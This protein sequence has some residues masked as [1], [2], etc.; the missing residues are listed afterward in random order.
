MKVIAFLL[1]LKTLKVFVQARDGKLAIKG[2]KAALTPDIKKQLGAAKQAIIDLYSEHGL[3]SNVQLAPVTQGQERMWFTTQVEADKGAYNIP[4]NVVMRGDVNIEA[5][6]ATFQAILDRQ[7]SLR[8]RF[9]IDGE[10]VYQVIRRNVAVDIPVIDLSTLSADEQQQKVRQWVAQESVVPFKLDNDLMLRVKLLQLSA[11]EV[12]VLY[13][14]HHIA[15]DGWSLGVLSNEISAL[16]QAF[17]QG[18]PD[19]LPP[20]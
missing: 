19:Q 12:I 2:N 4:R 16:Y 6:K 18:L 8:T 7:A 3:Q 11:N 10:Q 9:V 17:N 15:A 1:Q 14:L 20:L 13:T 5:L